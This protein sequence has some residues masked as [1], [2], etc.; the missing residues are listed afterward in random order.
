MSPPAFPQLTNGTTGSDRSTESNPHGAERDSEETSRVKNNV[1]TSLPSLTGL[2]SSACRDIFVVETYD[3]ELAFC[4]LQ[5]IARRHHVVPFTAFLVAWAS[6]LATYTGIIDDIT[7]LAILSDISEGR[8]YKLCRYNARE[9]GCVA[10]DRLLRYFSRSIPDITTEGDLASNDHCPE[11]ASHVEGTVLDLRALTGF[12]KECDVIKNGCLRLPVSRPAVHIKALVSDGGTLSFQ[13]SGLDTTITKDAAWLLLSQL[14]QALKAIVAKPGTSIGKISENFESRLLSISNPE[15]K[16]VTSFS[17]LQSQFEDFA[18]LS[19]QSIALEFC[20]NIKSQSPISATKWTYGSLNKQANTFATHLQTRFGS[21]I[22]CVVPICL[23]RCPELYIAILGILKVGAAWCPIDPSFPARRRHDL[24]LRSGGKALIVNCQSPHDGLPEGV[25]AFNMSHMNWSSTEMPRKPDVGPDDIAYLIWTSGTTGAP[26]GV[27]IHH[28]AA[29]TSMRALQASIPSDVRSGNVR[30][31]QFSQFTFD[32]FVQDLFYTWGVGGT[33]ISADRETM[34]GSF[35]EL[36]TNVRATHAHLTPAFAASVPRKKCPSLEVV[37]MIGEKL[38]TNVADDWSENCRLYN[39]YGPAETTVV[40]TLRLVP[41]RDTFQSANVG[42]PLPSVSAFVMQEENP[43]LRN[44]IGELALGGPQL[45]KGYW[46]DPT[47]SRE[48]FVWNERLKTTLYM[49]GDIVRQLFDGSLEFVGRTDDLVKIQGIRIELSEIAFALR[50]CHTKVEQVDVHFLNRPDRP[51]KVIVAFLAAPGLEARIGDV[52]T[53][54]AGIEIARRALVEAKTQLPEYMIPKVFVVV[55]SIARTS[56]A[57]VDRTVIQRLYAEMDLAAWERKL[58]SESHVDEQADDL[59]TDEA[60]VIE[61]IAKLTG[62]SKNAIDRHSTLPSIG[63]DSITATRLATMLHAQNVHLSIADILQ[64]VTVGDLL[65]RLFEV[66][67]STSV[68]AYDITA[69]HKEAFKLLDAYLAAR[70]ELVIPA[71]P[72]QESLLSESLRNPIS[73]W[74]HNFFVLAAETDLTKLKTA[75]TTVAERNDALRTAF[76]PVA[77]LSG[78]SSTNAT[79]LQ[80]IHKEASNVFFL[81]R[82]YSTESCLRLFVREYKP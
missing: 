4:D 45:S 59:S 30:C 66:H 56:S 19:P 67:A 2:R 68:T 82:I 13:S 81:S 37:T 42:Y 20:V 11:N 61:V 47:K 15:P 72:L 9:Q 64:S 34:L 48:R 8:S 78:R 63:V 46:N 6:I 69:F 25:H 24:V 75:W 60:A 80:L 79:F 58:G 49:T 50:S 1:L 17:P 53:D 54:E 70:I 27:P 10:I 33:L 39:T 52:I 44:G 3:S 26:K 43:V 77:E 62:T 12:D 21:L 16:A 18:Q 65:R 32:V 28:G 41:P 23:D 29:V 31:L 76:I 36:T 51:T 7:F 71:L 74:S 57:K 38:T 22:G 40:S 5:E 35:A 73:Y 55:T 14:D